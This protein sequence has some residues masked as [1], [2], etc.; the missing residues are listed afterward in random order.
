[1]MTLTNKG[2][3]QVVQ[4]VEQ[5]RTSQYDEIVVM[6]HND[7]QCFAEVEGNPYMEIIPKVSAHYGCS[8]RTA[9]DIVARVVGWISETDNAGLCGDSPHQPGVDAQDGR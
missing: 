2:R 5:A 7:A 9:E 3:E 4:L 8:W 1:M 6:H